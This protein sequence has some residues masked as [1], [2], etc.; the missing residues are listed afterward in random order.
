[1]E[2]F[3]FSTNISAVMTILLKNREGCLI[4]QITIEESSMRCDDFKRCRPCA[5]VV[6]I[7]GRTLWAYNRCKNSM[8]TMLLF[9]NESG[10]SISDNWADFLTD[11]FD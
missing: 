6:Y 3:D 1:M 8:S 9:D 2:I 10:T 11:V 4:M 5:Y 7:C